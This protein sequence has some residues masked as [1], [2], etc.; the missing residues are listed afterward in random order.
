MI[1]LSVQAGLEFRWFT[2]HEEFCQN[3]GLRDYLEDATTAYVMAISQNTEFTHAAGATTEIKNWP[4]RLRRTRRSA[5]RA[6]SRRK[7]TGFTSGPSSAP[8]API[9][10]T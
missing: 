9:I 2:A 6:Q 5:V 7:V 3:P 10:S 1:T 4:P 8:I